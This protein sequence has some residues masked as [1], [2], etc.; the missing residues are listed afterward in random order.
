MSEVKVDI[1]RAL[2]KTQIM[3]LLDRA[4]KKQA[5]TW[6]SMMIQRLQTSA[7]NLLQKGGKSPGN[8]RR[9]IGMSVS[10]DGREIMLGTG[11]KGTK[12]TVY[13]SIQDEGGV[14]HPKVTPK[15]KRFMWAMYADTGDEKYKWMALTKR[16]IFVV[17]IPATHWFTG[18]LQRELPALQHYMSPEEIYKKAEELAGK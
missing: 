6:A 12:S 16:G 18:P 4:A 10:S 1:T 17:K 11:V 5:T 14:T 3:L 15:M 2:H 13:A 8:L 7:L 9:S